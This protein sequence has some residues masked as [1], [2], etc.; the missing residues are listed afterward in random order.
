MVI[1]WSK[2][3]ICAL[4]AMSVDPPNIQDNWSYAANVNGPLKVQSI[5]GEIYFI[6]DFA[7]MLKI[8]ST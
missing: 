7:V 8:S 3:T 5:N 4:L 6:F 1:N 2:N